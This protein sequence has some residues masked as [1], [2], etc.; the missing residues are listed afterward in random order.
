MSVGAALG[1][2]VVGLV[3][4]ARVV[5]ALATQLV[6]DGLKPP[7]HR[8]NGGLPSQDG[9]YVPVQDACTRH[10]RRTAATLWKGVG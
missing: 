10:A 5:S 2:L 4:G 7:L 9:S 6:L 8:K 1:E 3:L